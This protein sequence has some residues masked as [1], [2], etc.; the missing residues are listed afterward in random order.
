MAQQHS[1]QVVFVPRIVFGVHEA[2]E[3]VDVHPA[4]GKFDQPVAPARR[5]PLRQLRLAPVDQARQGHQSDAEFLA[6]HLADQPGAE[7]GIR[8]GIVVDAVETVD[9]QLGGDAFIGAVVIVREGR[10]DLDGAAVQQLLPPFPA[11]LR[12][13]VKFPCRRRARQVDRADR[14]PHRRACVMQTDQHCDLILP[15]ET[16]FVRNLHPDRLSGHESEVVQHQ[17]SGIAVGT[18]RD[19]GVSSRRI[20]HVGVHREGQ[21]FAGLHRQFAH[22]HLVARFAGGRK[23]HRRSSIQGRKGGRGSRIVAAEAGPALP[24]RFGVGVAFEILDRRR[25]RQRQNRA[26]QADAE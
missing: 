4:A 26:Q 9:P 13:I 7:P 21:P 24:Q 11:R 6:L 16:P 5:Q 10:V 19:I 20:L 23:L 25:K 2:D 18:Q 14:D 12:R 15:V 3:A 8:A 17:I 1:V 22:D